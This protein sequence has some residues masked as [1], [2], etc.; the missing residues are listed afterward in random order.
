M[1]QSDIR[2]KKANHFEMDSIESLFM[3]QQMF[4]DEN[5]KFPDSIITLRIHVL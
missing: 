3:K 5:V 2:M 4:G 1:I